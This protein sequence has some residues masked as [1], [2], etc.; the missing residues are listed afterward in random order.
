MRVTVHPSL[1]PTF[2]C[3]FHQ[4]SSKE[5]ATHRRDLKEHTSKVSIPRFRPVATQVGR[6]VST[7][8]RASS[9]T[10]PSPPTVF[11]VSHTKKEQHCAG[12]LFFSKVLRITFSD[13]PSDAN[14]R[15]YELVRVAKTAVLAFYNDDC[16][17]SIQTLKFNLDILVT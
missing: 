9:L 13:C 7:G 4:E 16:T 12:R 14:T 15:T 8:S 3:S 10:S 1:H 17:K 2:C 5:D 11:C 6:C